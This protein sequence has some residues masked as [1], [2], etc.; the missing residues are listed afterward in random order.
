MSSATVLT[1]HERANVATQTDRVIKK[2]INCS[3]GRLITVVI[4]NFSL[5]SSR[6]Q[7]CGFELSPNVSDASSVSSSCYTRYGVKYSICI[8]YIRNMCNAI[9]RFFIC[10][11]QIARKFFSKGER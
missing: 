4:A 1:S 6:A 5:Q 9:I 2:N 3:S 11:L 8:Q 7:S 10:G